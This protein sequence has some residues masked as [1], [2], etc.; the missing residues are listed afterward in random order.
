MSLTTARP[1][2]KVYR[3]ANW[4]EKL[5]TTLLQTV[6]D[7]QG[8]SGPAGN[9][10]MRSVERLAMRI[11]QISEETGSPV[12]VLD[13]ACFSG[14]YLAKLLEMGLGPQQLRY[15]GVDVTPKY[16]ENSAK[17]FA[18]NPIATFSVASA[19][20]LGFATGAFDIVFNSGMLIH[21][22]DP[23]KCIAE[24][25]RVAGREA[26]IETTIGPNQA[27]DFVDENKSG[28]DFIDRVYKLDFVRQMI[29][30]NG[31]VVRETMVP[32]R[33]YHS[34]LFEVVPGPR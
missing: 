32:Y 6:Y 27:E 33:R 34:T 15:H 29:A 7:K 16:V 18:G 10:R 31:S 9:W 25:I 22:D 21:V 28:P 3:S 4:E 23:A 20:E 19:Y 2:S 14:D 30:R 13:V 5:D 12:R 8:W 11:R 24:F 26:L 1:T 17:R